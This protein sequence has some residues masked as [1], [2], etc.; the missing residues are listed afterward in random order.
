LIF[1]QAEAPK[2]SAEHFANQLSED[3]QLAETEKHPGKLETKLPIRS[4]L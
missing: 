4:P 3:W 1:T 2:D